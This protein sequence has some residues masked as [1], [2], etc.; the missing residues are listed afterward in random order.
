MIFY[1]IFGVLHLV[2][3]CLIAKR[4]NQ[5]PTWLARGPYIFLCIISF[6]LFGGYILAGTYTRILDNLPR[7]VAADLQAFINFLFEVDVAFRPAAVLYLIH[8]RGTI[9]ERSLGKGAFRPAMSQLWKKIFDWTYA[10]I[11]YI[12]WMVFV[13]YNHYILVHPASSSAQFNKYSDTRRRIVD[14]ATSVTLAFY[15]I[16]IV[17]SIIMFVQIKSRKLTDS[18]CTTLSLNLSRILLS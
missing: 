13:G 11:T 1:I 15:V 7:K 14:A 2:L 18:V 5:L 8:V 3:L 16:V 17:S 6:F 12:V 4:L 9:L 10:V